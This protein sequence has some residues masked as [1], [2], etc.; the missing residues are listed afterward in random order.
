MSARIGPMACARQTKL[1]RKKC[2]IILNL[3]RLA[4][5]GSGARREEEIA[6]IGVAVVGCGYRG[7]NLI[8]NFLGAATKGIDATSALPTHSLA[9]S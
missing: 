3:Y 7:Q 2:A 4:D 1:W 5:A 9:I 8:R 6:E